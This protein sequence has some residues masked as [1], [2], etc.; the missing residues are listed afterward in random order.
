M[1]M[2]AQS[3]RNPVSASI[4]IPTCNRAVV[5]RSTLE[6]LQHAFKPAGDD[7]EVIIVDNASSDNTRQVVEEWASK[8]PVA[9]QYVFESRAGVSYARNAGV[10]AARGELLLFLDDDILIDPEWLVEL[11]KTFEETGCMGVAGR[12]WLHWECPEPGWIA[13]D[14]SRRFH[15]LLGELDFG[16]E[17][18]RI[19][20]AANGANM[21]ARASA[22]QKYG[23][24]RTNVGV[25]G[26]H[27]T[28]G[29]D[30]EFF[31]RLVDGGDVVVYCPN[32]A[33]G[34]RVYSHQARMAYFRSRY[35][36]Y[37][38]YR[39]I[40]RGPEPSAHKILGVPRHLFRNVLETCLRLP[41]SGSK[42]LDRQ[43]ELCA[44]LGRIYQ[45]Y[46]DS[47]RGKAQVDCVPAA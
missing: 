18:I 42:R 45:H 37:G 41:F 15:K 35:F 7:V 36:R 5:L 39:V 34:H 30:T 46:L 12:I 24:F 1:M 23:L 4:V 47:K 14:T 40:T 19:E 38:R 20:R 21:A 8:A 9:V 31:R 32:A 22:F 16:P 13:A 28:A 6:S 2:A 29:G 10:A 26:S 25:G 27:P 33:V 11:R 44:D 3:Q 43:F 17:R